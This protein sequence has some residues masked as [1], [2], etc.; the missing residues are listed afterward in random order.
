MKPI[1]L[2]I[3]CMICG[4]PDTPT[5]D[6]IPEGASCDITASGK[7]LCIL[8][9]D[10]PHSDGSTD[11]ATL[12]NTHNNQS[13]TTTTQQSNDYAHC[14]RIEIGNPHTQTVDIGH[15]AQNWVHISNQCSFSIRIESN[16]IATLDFTMSSIQRIVSPLKSYST[17]FDFHPTQGTI[18][19]GSGDS[20]IR[21]DKVIVKISGL[22]GSAYNESYPLVLRGVARERLCPTPVIKLFK[23]DE[24]KACNLGTLTEIHDMHSINPGT[25][26]YALGDAS[27]AN[28]PQ[29]QIVSWNWRVMQAF[30]TKSIELDAPTQNNTTFV[31]DRCGIYLIELTVTD[32]FKKS[33][34]SDRVTVNV[35]EEL[36]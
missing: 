1:P 28:E 23:N 13:N 6:D 4:C 18:D 12:F 25:V 34:A 14:A 26:L 9:N 15:I 33:C 2:F 17:V 30:N 11:L 3:V 27:Y 21:S 16:A 36:Q 10:P 7:I 29:A 19:Y 22:N 20:Q 24:K 31:L 35:C 32:Q 5:A 8:T